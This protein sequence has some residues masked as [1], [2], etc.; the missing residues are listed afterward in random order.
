MY[1]NLRK[2]HFP[3]GWSTEELEN[4]LGG[5]SSE[6]SLLYVLCNRRAV[7]LSVA[8]SVPCWSNGNAPTSSRRTWT[9]RGFRSYHDVLMAQL[10]LWTTENISV[11]WLKMVLRSGML[12][13]PY[14]MYHTKVN[15]S[16]HMSVS[17]KSHTESCKQKI[18][19]IKSQSS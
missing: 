12:L 14:S 7:V 6:Y 10:Q 17:R 1:S 16:W 9:A 2:L 3:H 11:L 18:Y 19:T 15:V 5:T 8:K 13:R 4:H